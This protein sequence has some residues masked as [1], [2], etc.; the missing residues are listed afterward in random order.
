MKDFF[1][2]E[3]IYKG[4]HTSAVGVAILAFV[5]YM[6]VS[7]KVTLAEGWPFLLGGFGL[8]GTRD[9]KINGKDEQQNEQKPCK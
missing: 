3:N 7:G 8:L 4:K 2:Y 9:P 1:H 6:I 5:G